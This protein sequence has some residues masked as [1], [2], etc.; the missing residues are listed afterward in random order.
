MPYLMGLYTWV[1]GLGGWAYIW[2][3]V[4]IKD[5]M[6]LKRGGLYLEGGLIFGEG[7][8]YLDV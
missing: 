1:T 2:N 8:L 4:N 3:G 6:G 5:L 7:G